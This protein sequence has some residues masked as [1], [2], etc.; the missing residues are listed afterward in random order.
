[1]TLRLDSEAREVIGGFADPWQMAKAKI[2][3]SEV[4]NLRLDTLARKYCGRSHDAHNAVADCEALKGVYF[5]RLHSV[6][7]L[8]LYASSF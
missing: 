8:N 4:G 6:V 5:A 2:P 7:N 3:K 1:M